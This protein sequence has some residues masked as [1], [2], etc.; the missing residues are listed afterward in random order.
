MRSTLMEIVD[1]RI[2]LMEKEFRDSANILLADAVVTEE[3]ASSQLFVQTGASSMRSFLAVPLFFILNSFAMAQQDYFPDF[4]VTDEQVRL[5]Y[6]ACL[7]A[8]RAAEVIPDGSGR[9]LAARSFNRLY[10]IQADRQVLRFHDLPYDGDGNG[11]GMTSFVLHPD[12][13]NVGS[14]GYGKYY[15]LTGDSAPV[16][17]V[18]FS[19][20]RGDAHHKVLTEW[21]LDDIS[22]D[23]FSGTSRELIRF[24]V[25][26]GPHSIN[27]VEFDAEGMLYVATGEDLLINF[28]QVEDAVF[29]KVLRIDPFGNNSA[30]GQYGIPADNPFGNEVFAMGFRNP[31]RMSI[32]HVSGDIHV[33]DV[34]WHSIEEVDLVTLGAN[35]GWPMKEGS[36]LTS[37]E[38]ATP[39]LPDP[40]TGLTV[41]Q[42]YGFTDPIYE[43]DHTDGSAVIG[44]FV[45][46]GDEIPWLDG[47]Y[48]FGS[49]SQGDIYIG[50]PATG[51]VELLRP[52]GEIGEF[53][54]GAAVA[55]EPGPQG[56]ILLWGQDCAVRI[57]RGT[58]ADFNQDGVHDCTDIDQL[59][60]RIASGDFDS[61]FDMTGDGLL[62][63]ADIV[64]WLTEAGTAEIGAPFLEGDGNL[65][66][67]VDVSDFNVWNSSKFTSVN[68]WCSGD[69]NADGVADVS[70][71]NIWNENKF[72]TAAAVPEPS[73]LFVSVFFLIALVSYWRSSYVLLE[74]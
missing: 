72:Q 9:M 60:A 38:E 71:F 52:H 67:V 51:E 62:D 10:M 35:Y 57:S 29:G 20:F 43:F 49:F 23:S 6:H 12:F 59:V 15:T 18:D 48:I 26:G 19:S 14:Q 24:G 50:D 42:Q 40:D 25:S 56:G 8:V 55:I 63:Q 69:Y 17:P 65:D 44:G 36:Y 46:R 31:Y 2:E 45:Y 16:A 64:A 21:T 27:D 22:A 39:D 61:D 30:N 58:F 3:N 47:K 74:G 70:D 66:G 5:S 53:V 1:E 33:A 11:N 13:A 54:G 28:S 32:D 37:D 4:P 68:G 41:A 34:G 73:P 7:P